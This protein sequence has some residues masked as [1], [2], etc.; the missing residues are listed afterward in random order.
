MITIDPKTN[1]V[2]DSSGCWLPPI[3]RR[4]LDIFNSFKRYLLVTGCRKAGK[5]IGVE[6]KILRHAFDC[7][8][9]VIAII[10]KTIKNAKGSG[11]WT[12]LTETILPIW[13]NAGI[14]MELAPGKNGRALGVTGDSKMSY[15]KIRNR[16][17]SI[18]EIQLHSLEYASEVE[19]KFKGTRFSMFYLSEADRWDDRFVF[20]I[21]TDQLRMWPRIPYE[22]HQLIADCNPPE[23]G[24][25]NWLHDFWFK[26]PLDPTSPSYAMV[27][28]IQLLE[29]GLDDNPQLDPRERREL[30]IKYDYR[31][32]LRRRFIEGKWEQD[33]ITGHFSHVYDEDIHVLGKADGLKEN[34][35][36]I[37]PTPQ[38]HT[39][40]SGWD[41]GDRN[42][43]FHIMEKVMTQ[44]PGR[45]KLIVSFHIIDELVAINT[46]ISTTEFG[47]A[48]LRK[49]D[50]WINYQKETNKIDLTFRHWSDTSAWNQSATAG[51]TDAAV[52]FEATKERVGL[53][54]APRF[55]DSNYDKVSIVSE[56]LHLKRLFVSAQ[57]QRTRL[58]F[59]NL[60]SGGDAE[61]VKR[62]VHKHP[63]DSMSY[64]ILAEAPTDML[65]SSEPQ[66]ERRVRPVEFVVAGI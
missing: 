2:V 6:H 7:D 42:H 59:K 27:D 48:C 10:T 9:P 12:E 52:I 14:G 28:D 3:N 29:F 55:R 56:L 34:W 32:S 45:N 54:P 25:N 4:Q 5:T 39:L 17:G 21:L 8:G 44:A 41:I 22:Q 20:D 51:R 11:I 26:T 61:Y 40:L 19:A 23:T 62:D 43:S 47:L 36:V 30:E 64:P 53:R 63:F 38:C 18:S 16:H 13:L 58:M 33:I 35:E 15:L 31:P 49:I 37:V 57:L 24:P 66:T 60:R 46:L 50:Y 65:K 1:F